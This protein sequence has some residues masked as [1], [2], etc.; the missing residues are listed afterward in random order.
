MKAKIYLTAVLAALYFISAGQAHK[1]SSSTIDSLQH[2]DKNYWLNYANATLNLPP[3]SVTEF[4]KAHERHYIHE[5]YFPE[6]KQTP[7]SPVIQQACTNVDF[8]SG[9]LNGWTATTG[10]HPLFNAAG[11]CPT[12]GG[13]QTIMTGNGVDPCGGFPVVC[14]GGNFSVRLGNNGTGAVADR[15]EQKFFVSAANANFTYKYAVVFQDPGHTVNQQPAFRIEMFDSLGTAI[16]CTYY[17][18]A[19]GQNIAGFQNS[20]NCAGVVYKPWTNVVVDLTTY[21]GQSVTIRFSTFD[22]SLGGHYGYAYID[23]SCVSFQQTTQDTICVGSTKTLCAPTGFLSYVWSGGN[24]NGNTNQCVNVSNPGMY[25]V[26]TTLMT[27]CTG[28]IFYYPLHNFP[29]PVAN[30]NT[31]ANNGCGLTV[32]FNNNS[33]MSSGN[34]TQYQWNFGDGFTSTLQNPSHTYANAG[35]YLV[36]LIVTSSKGCKDT[37]VNLVNVNPPPTAA[38]SYSNICQGAPVMFNDNSTIQ[39]GNINQWSWNFGDNTPGSFLQNP[40]HIYANAGTYTVSLT[41]T[42]NQGCVATTTSVVTVNAK[43]NVNFTAANGCLNVPTVF[44]NSSSISGGAITSWMWDVDGNGIIDY[45]TA[46]ISHTYANAGT[47]TVILNASSNANCINSY[48]TTLTVHPLPL[49]NISGNNACHNS[50]TNFTNT[51][52]I[53]NNN[54]ITGY[55]WNFGNNTNTNQTS[56]QVIYSAPGNYVVTLTA[57]SNN[58]CV[59]SGTT[60]VSVFPNPNVS[61]NAASVCQGNAT[62]FNNTSGVSSG[63][64]VNWLW[65]LNG[66]SNA[67]S[68]S[69]NPTFI[70]P[71]AGIHVVSLTA[72]TN[73]NCVATYTNVINVNPLPNVSFA[74]NNAC[75]GAATQFTNNSTISSGQISSYQWAFGNG[76]GTFQNN[77][78]II[79]SN[80]GTYVATLTATSNNN[81]V[82]SA[83]QT[84][85]IH[86]VPN[87]NFSVTTTC[88]NQAT[89]FTNMSNIAS[90]NIVKYRWDFENNNTW[91]DS[92]ANPTFV[93][94]NFGSMQAK[95]QAISN[96]NCYSQKINPVVVHGNPVAN[97]KVNSACLGDN[98]NFVNLSACSD[99]LITSYQWDFNGDNI[100]DNNSQNPIHNYVTNGVYLAKLEVQSQYGC[101]NVM[102]KS[103]YV[104]AKPIAKFNANNVSGCPSLC[105][106]FTNMSTIS[107]G[108][109]VTNQWLFGDNSIPGYATNPTHCYETGTY[110]VTLKVVSDSGCISQFTSPSL[111]NVY[112]S[113]TAAFVVLPNEVD[114]N[115]P[116]IEVTNTSMGASSVSYTFSNGTSYNQQNFTHTFDTDNPMTVYITQIVVNNYGCKDTISQPVSI[117]P[118]FV[119]WVPNAFTPNSDGLNDG[120]MAKGVGINKFKMWIFDR[121]GRV[122]FET[123][124]IN[125]AWDGTVRGSEE[126]IK[127]DVYVWKAQVEDIFSKNHDLT[128][129]VTLIK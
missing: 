17:N 95:L 54:T 97:F 47:Y 78:A 111:V 65:D 110:N 25:S 93:Y 37:V 61:F 9:T 56:P 30:F 99:G 107:N 45:N 101:V 82:S 109:I 15:L 80:I 39:Q 119:I 38:F 5:T 89:Q 94:P 85:T 31:G 16:P 41:I 53:G 44:N 125:Q 48:S 103:V 122:I 6:Q 66:D 98:S 117:K 69:Q 92:T 4:I 46:N 116:M 90:G 19:A 114:M 51:S 1:I 32:N 124:D 70:Y 24:I 106:N 64:I 13:A 59:S 76:S 126:P 55:N 20:P 23:G 40:T 36:S 83:T 7:N 8:E 50:V 43:P 57:T 127:N 118:A 3:G 29:K 113:P 87:V 112:P 26:Q 115:Q 71:A 63:S 75:Q 27:G 67:D 2:F 88:L 60:L 96:N 42:S 21:I 77:P 73:N 14:P 12:A 22:C 86:A 49:I 52:S 68:T 62:Q 121:W 123:D 104:N 84:V 28:P 100:V 108:S 81:C 58:N 120:F 10:F 105:V 35:S 79:Y 33:S 74:V 72:I 129:H 128:G 11:C 91:D 34:L 102:S 18:V